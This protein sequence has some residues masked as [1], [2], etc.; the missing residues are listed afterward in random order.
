MSALVS[1]VSERGC[2]DRG[3]REEADG[4]ADESKDGGS[5]I[6]RVGFE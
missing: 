3:D 6:R 1:E 5:F 4:C 2:D